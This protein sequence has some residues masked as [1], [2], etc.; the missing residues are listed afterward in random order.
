M[1]QQAKGKQ[2]FIQLDNCDWPSLFLGKNIYQQVEIF[3]KILRNIFHNY[4]PNKYIL[5]DDKDPPWINEEIKTWIHR[6]NSLYQR[7]GKFSSIDYKSLNLLTLDISNAVSSSKLKYHERLAN[8]RND[9]KRAP[10]TYW[11]IIETFVNGSK[12]PLLPPLLVD[13]KLVT[14]VLDKANHFN[15]FFAKQ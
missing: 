15:N 4:M 8:K 12:I 9:P 3:N 6:K 11:V 1:K 2:N 5:C 13:N 7:Q 10:K 14:D